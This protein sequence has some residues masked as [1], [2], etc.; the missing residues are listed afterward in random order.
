MIRILHTADFHLDSPF[1]ALGDAQA[2]ERRRE[3][4][5][6]LSTIA[7]LAADADI[8]LLSG[9]LFDSGRPTGTVEALSDFF[10]K[11]RARVFISPGN[12][13]FYAPKSPYAY[14]KPRDNIHIFTSPEP[15]V[16]NRG[17]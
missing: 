15:C 12:H 5:E 7:R 8:V 3:Q 2:A 10:L 16:W 1:A 17:A 4:R 9:D 11:L 13:D 14:M 6:Q